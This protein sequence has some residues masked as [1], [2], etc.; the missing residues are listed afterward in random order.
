[1]IINPPKFVSEA[2]NE[3]GELKK[4]KNQLEN[5][6]VERIKNAYKTSIVSNPSISSMRSSLY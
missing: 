1:M 2:K 4:L 5:E 3:A 6:K